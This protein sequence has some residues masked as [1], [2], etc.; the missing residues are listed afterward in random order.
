M[1]ITTR[2]F[3]ALLLVTALIFVATAC[4]GENETSVAGDPTLTPTTAL[5]PTNVATSTPTS[6]P[7]HTAASMT[8]GTATPLSTPIPSPTPTPVPTPTPTLDAKKAELDKIADQVSEMRDLPLPQDLTFS[9]VSKEEMADFVAQW[10]EESY[11][12]EEALIDR[13]FLL[14]LDFVRESDDVKKV[15]ASR[16]SGGVVGFYD[17]ENKDLLILSGGQQDLHPDEKWVFVH[18][19][20]HALQ[21]GAIHLNSL[22]PDK[23]LR[24]D[25]LLA[26]KALV[27]GDARYFDG[28]YREELLTNAEKSRLFTSFSGGGSSGVREIK[29]FSRIGSFPYNEGAW[30]VSDL[31]EHGGVKGLHQA[32]ANPPQSTE[33]IL[34][35]DKYL[36]GEAPVQVDMPD[37]LYALGPSWYVLDSGAIGEFI[38]RLYLENHLDEWTASNAA[39]GWGGDSYAVVRDSV[40]GETVLVS[41]SVWDHPYE[42]QGFFEVY[43]QYAQQAGGQLT[44]SEESSR[45]W[46]G[47]KRYV[48]LAIDEDR[49]L[50]II[51]NSQETVDT[52]SEV[53]KP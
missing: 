12:E 5:T 3:A 7:T 31:V 16:Y 32:F 49:V 14:L 11:T 44:S 29:F 19:V 34:W 15:I 37:F 30:F 43:E 9:L 40:N 28:R 46:T 25:S 18:E 21:D 52:I 39:Y 23:W 41:L 51:G 24:K 4:A 6:R 2:L 35:P 27:E 1:I 22:Y 38:L 33:Q 36:D 53:V 48:H 8:P 17:R 13:E 20:V 50:L 42:A 47:D 10:V 26:R 45:S